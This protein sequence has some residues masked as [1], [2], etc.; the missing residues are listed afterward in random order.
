MIRTRDD[1][2]TFIQKQFGD[3][4]NDGYFQISGNEKCWILTR[5]ASTW[6]GPIKMRLDHISKNP[7]KGLG[8]YS[9]GNKY[10]FAPVN[11]EE[12]VLS[13]AEVKMW[14]IG[15]ELQEM[16]KAVL[17]TIAEFGDA[18]R[19]VKDLKNPTPVDNEVEVA[20]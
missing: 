13:F 1:V 15:M 12:E 5:K 17:A 18:V 10:F 11:T 3:H 9:R 2:I 8:I 6:F 16:Q 4:L 19:A 20:A 14:A 7:P